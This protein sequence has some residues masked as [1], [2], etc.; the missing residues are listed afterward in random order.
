M[1]KINRTRQ[2]YAA[3]AWYIG[4]IPDIQP[5]GEWHNGAR[6]ASDG[7]YVICRF[8]YGNSAYCIYQGWIA[9]M[10]CRLNPVHHTSNQQRTGH[11]H[12]ISANPSAWPIL[13]AGSSLI[14]LPDHTTADRDEYLSALPPLSAVFHPGQFSPLS[15]TSG[16]A[17]DQSTDT[18]MQT[19]QR[20]NP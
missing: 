13:R 12:W 19:T 18:S 6:S 16:A 17:T 7:P 1:S 15:L 14:L 20:G 8:L 9:Y 5:V 10:E 3:S 11:R 2:S 4:V